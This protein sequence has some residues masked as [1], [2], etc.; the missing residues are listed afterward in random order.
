MA[1]YICHKCKI[2]MEATNKDIGAFQE[3]M[4]CPICGIEIIIDHREDL[5]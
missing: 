2:K 4:K 5:S 1:K 3:V